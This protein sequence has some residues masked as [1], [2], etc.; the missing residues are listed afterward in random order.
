MTSVSVPNTFLTV[1]TTVYLQWLTSFKRHINHSVGHIIICMAI[2]LQDLHHFPRRVG[3]SKMVMMQ[4]VD[5]AE[6]FKPTG[7]VQRPRTGSVASLNVH[8]ERGLLL[9][10]ST[11][12]D[13]LPGIPLHKPLILVI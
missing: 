12:A 9:A 1:T 13:A 10:A 7:K 4:L 8:V 3:Q 6:S 11:L 5:G 2:L